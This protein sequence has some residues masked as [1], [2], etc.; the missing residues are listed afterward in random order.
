MASGEGGRGPQNKLRDVLNIQVEVT[1]RLLDA[2]EQKLKLLKA[3]IDVSRHSKEDVSTKSKELEMQENTLLRIRSQYQRLLQEMQAMGV[4]HKRNLKISRSLPAIGMKQT[5]KRRPSVFDHVVSK[6][7][8]VESKVTEYQKIIEENRRSVPLEDSKLSLV[9]TAQQLADE[10]QYSDGILVAGSLEGLIQQ[11]IPTSSYYPERAY[12]FAFLLCS[13]LFVSPHHLLAKLFR[14][15]QHVM[16]QQASTE[17]SSLK[18]SSASTVR[19]IQLIREWTETFPYDF[20]DEKM[21]RALKD[22][23]QLCST[24]LPEQRREI[25]QL[26][27]TLIQKL[28][29]LDK[30]EHIL[31]QVNS[32]AMQRLMDPRTQVDILRTCSEPLDLARQL[33]HIELER[34]NNIGPEEFIQ[35][36]VKSPTDSTDV[37]KTS[38]IEA[39]VE[40]FNRLSYLVATEICVSDKER[41]RIRLMEFFVDTALE[42]QKLNNFNSFMAIATGLYMSPV[43]RLKKTRSKLSLEKLEEL[44]RLLDPSGNFANY[45]SRLERATTSARTMKMNTCVVPFFSL[46]VKDLYFQNESMS[47]KL[48]NGFIR[49]EKCMALARLVLPVLMWRDTVL[50]YERKRLL[51]NYLMTV[52]IHTDDELLL[53]SYEIEA[54][55]NAREKQHYQ[56]LKGLLGSYARCISKGGTVS[57]AFASS[58]LAAYPVQKEKQ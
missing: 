39:Y 1:E 33:T 16:R 38:N 10:L 7:A 49:F 46:I 25:G 13:R 27:S 28:S 44:E 31:G 15:F 51:L 11:L 34:L 5:P 21:M 47:D 19:F 42:C 35:T 52:P 48:P 54:P 40:W 55:D 57:G 29:T 41:N 30:Y 56:Q 6:E 4:R 37:K 23:T 24:H 50:P 20:R 26:Q 43:V 9:F 18:K 22:V 32:V 2:E 8:L 53:V 36:F 3:E 45:R 12:V 14:I 58:T 17:S